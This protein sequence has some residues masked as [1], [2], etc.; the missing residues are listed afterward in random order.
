LHRESTCTFP[1]LPGLTRTAALKSEVSQL[2][3]NSNNLL[4]L[5]RQ[6]RDGSAVE[7]WNLLERIRSGQI[8]ID[9]PPRDVASESIIHKSP[10]RPSRLV[11]A[12]DVATNRPSR[13]SS[14]TASS[15]PP[16]TSQKSHVTKRYPVSHRPFKK[17]DNKVTAAEA[18]CATTQRKVDSPLPHQPFELLQHNS[19]F[20]GEDHGDA[21][22]Q[23]SLRRH[24]QSI[25]QGFQVQQSCISEVFFCHSQETFESLILCLKPGYAA[26][27]R[28]SVL[29]E[30]CAVAI[31]AGQYV[32]DSLELGLLDHWYSK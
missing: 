30:I 11:D 7:A 2:K 15:L 5:Y 16:G 9:T 4:G 17:T 20:H 26:T 14:L 31:I 1:S 12:L 27:P 3:N 18:Q 10:S 28:S 23:L 25:Q 8:P 24:L 29:C 6:L 22:L 32:R 21:S 19:P 13:R